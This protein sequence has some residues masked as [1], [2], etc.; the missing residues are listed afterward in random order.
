MIFRVRVLDGRNGAPVR[1]AHVKLWYDEPAGA[2]YEFATDATGSGNM[3]APVGEPI[4]VLVATTDYT[5]CRRPLRGDP[6]LGYSMA[7]IAATGIATENGCGRVATR[8]HP[9]E[10]VL[11]VRSP[12]WYEGINRG[13]T[14]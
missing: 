13:S 7:G 9:G 10:L 3:P 6:P 14:N 2:G 4:R 1:N 11:F 8:T 12:H 5:D